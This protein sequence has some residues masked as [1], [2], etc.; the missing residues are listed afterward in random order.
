MIRKLVLPLLCAL[1]VSA[2]TSVRV[3][4]FVTDAVTGEPISTAG[5]TIGQRYAHVDTAGHY[6]ISAKKTWKNL[7][8]VAPGYEPK[9]MTI[10][11]SKARA[12]RVD[13]QMT[14]RKP[15]KVHVMEAPP[16]ASEKK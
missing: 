10:D 15:P 4:G 5:I 6:I 12:P 2:C 16:K 1:A 8:L 9:T 11:L 14:P 7:Q 3:Q 13:V